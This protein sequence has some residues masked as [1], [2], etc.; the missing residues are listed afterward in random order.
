MNRAAQTR[1]DTV[2]EGK[3]EDHGEDAFEVFEEAYL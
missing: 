1:A 2:F 3:E